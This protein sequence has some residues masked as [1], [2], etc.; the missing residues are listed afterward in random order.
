VTRTPPPTR[1][2]GISGLVLLF[3]V[4]ALAAGLAFDFT[5][6]RNAWWLGATAGAAAII[7]VAAALLVVMAGHLL[8]LA[9]RGRGKDDKGGRDASHHA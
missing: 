4:T 5:T 9:L 2:K 3:C 1:A 6:A 8:R 7:G